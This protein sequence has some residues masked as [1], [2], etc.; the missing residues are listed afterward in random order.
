MPFITRLDQQES[1]RT[2]CAYSRGQPQNASVDESHCSEKTLNNRGRKQILGPGPRIT[3]HSPVVQAVYPITPNSMKETEETM[4]TRH[5]LRPVLKKAQ[6]VNRRAFHFLWEESYIPSLGE[7]HLLEPLSSFQ[8]HLRHQILNSPLPRQ[9]PPP[10]IHS[11]V[12]LHQRDCTPLHPYKAPMDRTVEL[13]SLQ[14]KQLPKITMTC[15]TPSPKELHCT[16]KRH[17]AWALTGVI[18]SQR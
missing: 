10:H 3:F 12:F 11:C 16:G 6:P 9:G 4:R 1:G 7:A 5:P 15:P 14:G 8:E 18:Y 17:V 13:C 2:P